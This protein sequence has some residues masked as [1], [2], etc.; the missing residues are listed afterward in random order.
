[1]LGDGRPGGVPQHEDWTIGRV[2]PPTRLEGK[3]RIGTTSVELGPGPRPDP[4]P[5]VG[6]REL[7]R[8]VSGVMADV[9]RSGRPVVVTKHGAPF[10]AIVPIQ[11]GEATVLAQAAQ[12]LEAMAAEDLRAGRTRSSAEVFAELARLAAALAQ[13][14]SDEDA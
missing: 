11:R 2:A 5:T 7:A 8:N 10:A 13:A 6:I 1:M 14:A 3:A 4:P 9:V 12:H